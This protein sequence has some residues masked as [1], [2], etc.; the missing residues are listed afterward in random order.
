MLTCP[1]ALAS[2][3]HHDLSLARIVSHAVCRYGLVHCVG[4][5]FNVGH[6]LFIVSTCD[7]DGLVV[8]VGHISDQDR[9]KLVRV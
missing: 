8:D 9:F 3:E 6:Q 7:E 5:L 4:N 1:G 2:P